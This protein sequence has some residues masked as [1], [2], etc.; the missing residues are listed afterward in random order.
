MKMGALTSALNNLPLVILF[1]LRQSH[2]WASDVEP[3]ACRNSLRVLLEDP[4][5]VLRVND[6]T[7]LARI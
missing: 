6:V 3:S 1:L 4:V 2:I 7:S 5:K